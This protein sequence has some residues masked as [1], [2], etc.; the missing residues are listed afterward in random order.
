M[1]RPG[2]VIAGRPALRFGGALATGCLLVLAFPPAD[3][4]WLAWIAL[5]PLLLSLH[6]ATPGQAFRLGAAAGAVGYG[7]LM[8]WLRVFGAPTWACVSLGMAAF[9]GAF[10]ALA[11]SLARHYR[12]PGGGAWVW[13]VPV[14]WVSV[15]VVRSVGPLGFPWGL[16]GLTQYRAPVVLPLASVGGVFGVGAVVAL[17]NTSVAA[18]IVSRRLTR[19]AAA[20]A[21][22][23]LGLVALSAAMPRSPA[24]ASRIVAAVQPNIAPVQ[25]GDPSTATALL[26]GLLRQTM[27]ARAA[28]AQVIVYPETAV[29]L[30]VSTLPAARSSIARTAGGATV[31]AGAFLPGP[32][33]GVVVIGASGETL[34]RYAKRRLVPFG[35]AGVRPGAD[36]AAV[37][38]PAGVIGLAICYESAFTDLLRSLAASGAD[39]LAVL[40]NDGWFGASAGPA[41]HAAHAVLRAV[42]TGRS[43]VRAA[44]TGTS[45]LIRPD[46][47]VVAAQPIGSAG[48]LVASLPVGGPL[49]PY[50][51]WGWV[52]APLA[53]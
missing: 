23:A 40:T 43:V 35:E 14:C 34:G 11:A 21:V 26:D 49:T 41:Q 28:G 19:A 51:R 52:V 45:M 7:G 42:E 20:G 38:T 10:A 17:V 4:G 39:L 47:T 13:I 25:K 36:P 48:V 53:L 46:G 30:E 9:L 37:R 16:L 18:V 33:N 3:L 27:Q 32:H 1:S 44:N 22:L 24:G 12:R 31:V 50:V 8:V 29:P 6:D 15:E 5:V 2:G